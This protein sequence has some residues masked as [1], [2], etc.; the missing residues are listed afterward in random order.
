MET[1]VKVIDNI[2]E[3]RLVWGV[4]TIEKILS[5]SSEY[6]MVRRDNKD[7]LMTS[8]TLEGFSDEIIEKK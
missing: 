8:N 7:F 3:A 2:E 4:E 1:P 6:W 5:E